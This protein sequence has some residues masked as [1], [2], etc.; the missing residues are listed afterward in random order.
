MREGEEREERIRRNVERA[1]RL[2]EEIERRRSGGRSE[3][4]GALAEQQW[5]ASHRAE[6]GP[7]AGDR[8]SGARRQPLAPPQ[9]QAPDERRAQESLAHVR[10][11]RD[12]RARRLATW[13]QPGLRISGRHRLCAPVRP[14]L[15]RHCCSPRRARCG[16]TA[17]V[18]QLLAGWCRRG[19][20]ISL[21]VYAACVTSTTTHPSCCTV[22]ARGRG[23]RT[24]PP[25]S[26]IARAA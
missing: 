18:A 6:R 23:Q 8:P 12:L 22:S 25:A 7:R 19:A 5:L 9:R 10:A 16:V 4:G 11:A 15:R 1:K 13:R 20:V 2:A 26:Q 14:P 24:C 21:E 3:V 17:L